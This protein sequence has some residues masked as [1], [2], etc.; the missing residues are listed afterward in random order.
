MMQATDDDSNPAL[1]SG[2]VVV[3][4]GVF[5]MGTPQIPDSKAPV[6]EES[7][8]ITDIPKIGG[9]LWGMLSLLLVPPIA[10][11]L[12]GNSLGGF[13]HQTLWVI[14]L[15]LPFPL[16]VLMLPRKYTLDNRQLS[17]I[18]VFYRIRVPRDQIT[19][20]ERMAVGLALIHPSSIFCSD[21]A[22]ALRVRRQDRRPLI[23]SPRNS[24]PFLGLGRKP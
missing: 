9:I 4:H 15:G 12:I 14:L 2:I 7:P 8:S 11:T 22:R 16:T 24:E 5:Q 19:A 1:G 18:G 13:P 21:P 3:F 10:L 23:I 6:Q 20:V 17:V